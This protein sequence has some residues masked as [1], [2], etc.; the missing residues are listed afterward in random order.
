VV[1]PLSFSPLPWKLFVEKIFFGPPVSVL[2]FP[3]DQNP[4]N[5]FLNFLTRPFLHF[6]FN[7]YHFYITFITSFFFFIFNSYRKLPR[8]YTFPIASIFMSG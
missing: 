3:F 5:S 1:P 6:P 7:L 2:I 8:L 4:Q